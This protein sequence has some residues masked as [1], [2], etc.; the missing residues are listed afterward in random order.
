MEDIRAVLDSLQQP[1]L[2]ADR[3]GRV[4]LANEAGLALLPPGPT[5]EPDAAW[6]HGLGAPGLGGWQR[7]IDTARAFEGGLTLARDAAPWHYR[8]APV[9]DEGS[10]ARWL[11]TLRRQAVDDARSQDLLR[12][13]LSAALRVGHMG[14][15]EWSPAT[16]NSLWSPELYDVLRLPRG[17]GVEPGARFLDMVHPDDLHLIEAAV[18]GAESKGGI[19]PFMFRV[20]LGD[21]TTRWV[22]TC[23]VARREPGQPISRLVG[24]NFDVT[25]TV[26][27]ERHLADARRARERQEQIVQ[28]VMAHAPVGIAVALRGEAEMAYV[29][30][31]GAD[32]LG[33]PSPGERAWDAWQIYH[34]D[35]RTPA[36][37]DELALSRAMAGEVIRDEEWFIRT[38]D[39]RLL[40]VSCNAG[41]IQAG[42]GQVIGGTVVWYDVSPFKELQRQRELFLAAVSHEL[43][44]PLNA[45]GS[46]AQALGRPAL[47]PDLLARASPAIWR[48]VQTAAR[49][50]EDLLDLSRMSAG[51]LSLNLADAD[52]TQILQA[53]VDTV[54]P[55][56]DAAQVALRL[57]GLPDT[58]LRLKADEQRLQ[59]AVCNLLTNAV[60]FS[61]AGASVE[62]LLKADGPMAELTVTDHGAG[63]APAHLERVFEHFW[64]ADSRS[65]RGLGLGLGLSIARHIVAGHGGTLS[66]ASP[67]LDR[68]AS[69]CLRVPLA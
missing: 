9:L 55:L 16:G 63:I 56:A 52:L 11:I 59:Q 10:G 36:Q 17:S 61:P 7:G 18:A 13:G 66:A 44:T 48:N 43:R 31:F 30:R 62:V 41:P 1:A 34:V 3:H 50:L 20:M 5:P 12:L 57:Q 32:M 25:D 60:K 38:G 15:W 49:L 21:G 28:A 19:D 4:L 42:D 2:A 69:F 24:V 8:A 22:M 40:P 58:P 67:G 29:S 27:A 35:G 23:A 47:T 37:R 64:Q 46:W 68:G 39:G 26:E 45:I 51:H 14:L 54:A 6:R 33:I 53:A 65:S